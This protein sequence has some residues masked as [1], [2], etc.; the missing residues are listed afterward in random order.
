VTHWAKSL[1]AYI[2]HAQLVCVGLYY[3]TVHSTA[4]LVLTGAMAAT[5]L[6]GARSNS[7]LW[8]WC[9]TN[10]KVESESNFNVCDRYAVLPAKSFKLCG[11]RLQ[12]LHEGGS[13]SF[14]PSLQSIH[15]LLRSWLA[16]AG[17]APV[18]SDAVG[19]SSWGGMNDDDTNKRL[20]KNAR[21]L[22]VIDGRVTCCSLST[23]PT[24]VLAS[25]RSNRPTLVDHDDQLQQ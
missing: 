16:G 10:C 13:I 23:L 9:P 21:I 17:P 25:H 4:L 11:S 12:P 3:Y 7:C 22:H 20:S 6:C 14:R 19:C 8:K 24:E 2:S 18:S 1:Y 15:L 5:V